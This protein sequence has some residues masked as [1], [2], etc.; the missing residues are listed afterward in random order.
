M[1]HFLTSPSNT[2][3]LNKNSNLEKVIMKYSALILIILF[4]MAASPGFAGETRPPFADKEALFEYFK[5]PGL[6]KKLFFQSKDVSAWLSS[7][8]QKSD[9]KC[10]AALEVMNQSFSQW[11]NLDAKRGF[12]TVVNCRELTAIT[13]PNPALHKILGKPIINSIRDINGKLWIL[14]LCN[15]LATSS[16]GF[17]VSQFT[18]WCRSITGF[19][20]V[21]VISL[22]TRVPGTDYQVLSHL[23]QNPASPRELGTKVE[24]LNKLADNWSKEWAGLEE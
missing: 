14:S 3:C 6:A 22:L 10:E 5:D 9:K 16:N 1:L 18:S 8:C 23:L 20:E 13:H 15:G 11:N 21:W 24:E 12:H 4:A 17:W 7:E 19:N 2:R